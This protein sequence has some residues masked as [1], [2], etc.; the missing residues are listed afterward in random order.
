M[1]TKIFAIATIIVVLALGLTANAATVYEEN[2]TRLDLNGDLQIQLRQDIGD[3]E[4]LYVDY[5]DLTVKFSG[6]QDLDYGW[7]ALGYL[8]MDWKKDVKGDGTDKPVD[9]AYVGVDFGPVMISGGLRDWGSN[10]YFEVEEAYE[11]DGGAA[12]PEDIGTDTLRADASL[13]F[14]NAVLSH[15]LEVDDDESATDVYVYTDFKGIEAGLLY[16]TYKD[17]ADADSVETLGARIAYDFDFVYLG[18][19]YST[20]DSG[21]NLNYEDVDHVNLVAVVPI[22]DNTECAFGYGLES[23]DEGD[24]INS[25]YANITH[26]LSGNVSVL[27]EIG[28]TDEDDTDPGYVAGLRFKF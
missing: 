7:T 9:E 22:L 17:N 18:A 16:Q 23:P 25:W 6:K 24:D 2:G 28:D 14:I 21:D 1:K 11:F 8:E 26:K 5:D 15:E 20:L 12:F 13:G 19:D 10:D 27:A 4:D 3:D